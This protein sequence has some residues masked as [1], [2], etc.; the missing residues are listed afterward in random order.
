[1]KRALLISN[2]NA[3]SVSPRIRD[4]IAHAL[5]TTAAVEVAE[6]KRRGHATH[7]ARGAAHDGVD[8]V[9]ALGGDG[10]ANE[11]VNGIMRTRSSILPL[12]GGGTNVFARTMGYPPDPVEATAVALDLLNADDPPRRISVGRLNGRAFA[13]CAGIGVDGAI[14][15]AVERRGRMK[16]AVGQ[17]FFVY[18]A[19]RALLFSYPRKEAPLRIADAG[20]PALKTVFVCNSDPYTFWGE[21]PL[22]VCPA[23]RAD[24]GL[25]VTALASLR[26]TRLIRIAAGAFGSGRHIRMRTVHALHDVDRLDVFTSKPIPYQLDGEYAGEDVVFTVRCERDAL[27]VIA[28]PTT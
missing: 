3:S 19:L 1:M 20:L 13:F 10:T 18:Q 11:V 26:P 9:V 5:S 24:A 8:I 27:S 16:R 2:P 21:R 15:R 28:G 6:T 14:V 22:R 25:D 17:A 7:L 4:V 23:A 12:P